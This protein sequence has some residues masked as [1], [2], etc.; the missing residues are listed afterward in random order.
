MINDI[1]LVVRNNKIKLTNDK[2]HLISS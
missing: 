1:L 2:R